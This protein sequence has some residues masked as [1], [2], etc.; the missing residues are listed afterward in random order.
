MT[1]DEAMTLIEE[2]TDYGGSLDK[3]ALAIAIASTEAPAASG[4]KLTDEQIDV[5]H[6]EAAKTLARERY[7]I[8]AGDMKTDTVEHL[9]WRYAFARAI[10]SASDSATAT[11]KE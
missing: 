5:I 7:G 8:D 9:H 2:H 3:H 11:D 4:Q 1:Y 6:G 10:L